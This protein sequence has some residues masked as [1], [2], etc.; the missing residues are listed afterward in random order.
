MLGKQSRHVRDAGCGSAARRAAAIG[1]ATR[2]LAFTL[3]LL[4]MFP[5]PPAQAQFMTAA[6]PTGNSPHANGINSVTNRIYVA[7]A[8]DGTLTVIDGPR[9]R[10]RPSRWGAI[11]RRWL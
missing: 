5:G 9:I 1:T 7:N 11:P 3:G 8:D 4:L 2:R 10:Q 6:V